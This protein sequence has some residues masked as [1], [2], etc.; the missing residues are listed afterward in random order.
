MNKI[1]KIR[2]KVETFA[3]NHK[4]EIFFGLGYATCFAALI[5]GTAIDKHLR[6]Q[7][8]NQAEANGSQRFG[9]SAFPVLDR[10][11]KFG[12]VIPSE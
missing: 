11:G 2:D 6:K 10:N 5:A 9:E 8:W 4:T 3:E 7:M 12:W 1:R